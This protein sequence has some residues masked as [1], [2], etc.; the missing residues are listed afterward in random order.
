VVAVQNAMLEHAN[1]TFLV[2]GFPR[3]VE[4]AEVPPST[5]ELPEQPRPRTFVTT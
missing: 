2:D 1:D 3:S 4:Q 5:H